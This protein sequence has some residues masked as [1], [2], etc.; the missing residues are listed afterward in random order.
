MEQ[1]NIQKPPELCVNP[2]IAS[3][4]LFGFFHPCI[5]LPN[6]DISE[7]DFQYIVLHEL[8]HCERR[9]MFY[10]WLVQVTVCLHWFNPFAYL[11]NQEMIKACEFSYD[12]AVLAKIGYDN[13]QEYG[14][15]LLDAMAAVGKY[16]ENLGAVTLNANKRLLK[17]RLGAIMNCKR[18]SRAAWFLTGELTLCAIVGAV[19]IGVYPTAAASSQSSGTPSVSG[20]PNSIQV[21]TSEQDNK[22]YASQ[23]KR[24]YENDSLPLFE[25]TF[26]KLD[27]DMK[28][29]WLEKLYTDGDFAFFSVVARGLDINSSLFT[30]FAEKM[31]ADKEIAFFSILADYMNTTK[32]EFWLDRALEDG[33]WD[34]QSMLFDKLDKS[35]EFDERK[36]NQE[37]EWE[38]AQETEYKAVGVTIDGYDYYYQE[39]LVNIFLDIQSSGS[40]Y[41]L[42][43]N[44]KGTVNVKIIRNANNKIIGIA[45]MTETEVTELLEDMSDND[46][47]DDDF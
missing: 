33:K 4:L 14:K 8:I 47:E 32:L 18:K 22:D 34:F 37:K 5:V 16:K 19:F 36:E 35:D 7:K 41:T 28:K 38:E 40:F 30:D 15:T 11:M 23:V 39:Q 26:P 24:Y 43:M 25:I 21:E 42:N 13:A 10:K 12:E 17:A 6:A 46:W 31:Y 9:D 44:P 1:T 29:T 3:P 45:Y 2:L 20:K 27:E